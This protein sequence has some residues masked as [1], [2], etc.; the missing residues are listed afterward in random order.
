MMTTRERQKSL[1]E[2]IAKIISL[3]IGNMILSDDLVSLLPITEHLTEMGR[4]R[5]EEKRW[6]SST[7][8]WSRESSHVTGLHGEAAVSVLTGLPLCC[9]LISSGDGGHDFLVEGRSVDVKTSLY[10]Q[11]PHL[12]QS[13]YPKVW[14]DFYVLAAMDTDTC[15]VRVCGWAS[16]D[17]L[18]AAKQVNY[19]YG[20]RLSMSA[21]ELRPGLPDWMLIN[22]LHG[23]DAVE[24]RGC[25]RE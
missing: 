11:D 15:R 18:R 1:G 3:E 17:E 20:N 22:T 24:N 2:E 9:E 4:A 23:G 14:S 16:R 12:K 8:S 21:A 13:Q 10:W 7:S 19:G 6:L 25:L 5:D